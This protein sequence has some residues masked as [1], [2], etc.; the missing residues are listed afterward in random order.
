MKHIWAALLA[1]TV[2]F[3]GCGDLGAREETDPVQQLQLLRQAD[4]ARY[5]DGSPARTFLEWWR[6]LQ[7]NSPVNAAGQYADRVGL[8]RRELE[9]QLDA[10]Q[11]VLGLRARPRVIDVIESGRRATV[12]VLFTEVERNPNGRADTRR[13]PQS[14]DLVRERG[15]WKLSDNRYISRTLRAARTFIEEGT[16]KQRSDPDPGR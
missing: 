11:G 10:G 16:N 8:T 12:F 7:F 3:A 9:R 14:F 5:P 6:A 4:L 2:V 15:E 13:S 1:M